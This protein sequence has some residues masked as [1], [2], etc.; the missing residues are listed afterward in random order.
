MKDIPIFSTDN[1]VASLSLQQIPYTGFAHIT[2]HSTVAFDAFLRECVG[3]CRAAGA[4]SILANG[5]SNLE[6][7]PIYTKILRMQTP[8]PEDNGQACLFPLTENTLDTWRAI[9]NSRMKGVP[10]A[11]IASKQMVRD[12]IDKRTAYFVHDNGELLGIGVVEEDVIRAIASCKKGAGETVMKA[13]C[14][15]VCADTVKV[16]VAEN[17]L[18]A[19]KLYCRMGFVATAIINTWYDVSK[20]F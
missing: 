8:T 13:L 3:F 20:I 7:Y 18:P 17:N 12:L 15:A 1:G 2:I 14:G 11:V 10:N 5:H 4:D 16:E 9:Y 19:M 6:C